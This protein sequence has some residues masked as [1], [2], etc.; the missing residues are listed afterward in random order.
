LALSN[1]LDLH[2]TFNQLGRIAHIAEIKCLTG[3]GTVGP[4]MLGGCILTVEPGAPGYSVIDRIPISPNL[5]I[6]AGVYESVPTK[7]FLSTPRKRELVNKFGKKTLDKI[8]D[9]PSLDHFMEACKEFAIKTG[10]VTKRIQKLIELAEKAGA[11][12]ATQNMIGEA[13][14]AVV[15]SE[16]KQTVIQ[17]FQKVLPKENIIIARITQQGAHRLK[18]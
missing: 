1:V 6:V 17:A 15:P 11:I 9:N 16:K 4:L 8:L 10:I 18:P 14:H 2:L 3:L 12:G 13:V 5:M 7:A